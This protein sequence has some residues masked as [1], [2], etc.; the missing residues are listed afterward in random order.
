LT[1]KGLCEAKPC[2]K[3][4]AFCTD[5]KCQICAP[6][7]SKSTTT[8]KCI[9]SKK[10]KN[11]NNIPNCKLHDIRTPTNHCYQCTQG[12]VLKTDKLECI[13]P[14]PTHREKLSGCRVFVEGGMERCGECLPGYSQVDKEDNG[15]CKETVSGTGQKSRR[16]RTENKSLLIRK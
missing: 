7:Y 6:N 8:D 9:L 14:D 5:E 13:K 16:L 1:L 12:Y 15:Y 2:E 11:S 3:N 10:K 4:C